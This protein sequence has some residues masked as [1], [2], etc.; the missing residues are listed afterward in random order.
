MK[1]WCANLQEKFRG[2]W[3]KLVHENASPHD[4]ALGFA[5]GLFATFYPIPIID[6]L[7]ALVFAWIIRANKSACLIGNNFV[8]LIYPVI[9]LLVGVEFCVGKILLNAP[10][11]FHAPKQ[12]NLT[13][14]FRE[15]WPNIEAFLLGGVVLGLPSAIASYFGVRKAAERWQGR[16]LPA[17]SN[18]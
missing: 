8:L 1:K 16:D 15:S 4:I 18:F 7:V 9:P 2:L 13:C 12:W 6:T 17:Q 5:I 10:I 14:L 11:E 3:D